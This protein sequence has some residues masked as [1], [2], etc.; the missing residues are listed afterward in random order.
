MKFLALISTFVSQC[1]FCLT[2]IVLSYNDI[3]VSQCLI[4]MLSHAVSFGLTIYSLSYNVHFVSQ[5]EFCL[6]KFF[7]VLQ[8]SFCLTMFILFDKVSFSLIV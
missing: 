4:S 7:S 3:F 2:M 6:I 5:N 1:S 8:F